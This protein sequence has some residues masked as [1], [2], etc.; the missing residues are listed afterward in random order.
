MEET[1]GLGQR[2]RV[3]QIVKLRDGRRGEVM[4]VRRARDV[5][6]VLAEG[7]AMGFGLSCR[8]TYGMNWMDHYFQADVLIRGEIVIAEPYGIESV[9]SG[10]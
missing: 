9:E 10:S 1:L 2:P 3:G 4:A 6:A 7:P 8:S 5:L